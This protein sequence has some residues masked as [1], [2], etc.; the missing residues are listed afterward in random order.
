MVRCCIYSTVYHFQAGDKNHRFIVFHK[1][2][3]IFGKE[4]FDVYLLPSVKR[5]DRKRRR[6][7]FK[8]IVSSVKTPE[9]V[10][11]CCICG[12]TSKDH[13]ELKFAYCFK[14]GS[15]YEYCQDHLKNHE[16]V[17]RR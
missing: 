5:L 11:T 10:Y 1:F 6:K 8:V 7:K 17:I 14:C 15:D 3:S 16:H 4:V 12:R 9:I 2:C 13:P